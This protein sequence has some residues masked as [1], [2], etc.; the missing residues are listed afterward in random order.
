[1]R[2]LLLWCVSGLAL[3]AVGAAGAY[4]TGQ[5]QVPD[6]TVSAGT[7][8]ISAEPTSAALSVGA[9][10]PGRA[11]TRTMT[12]VN[13]GDLPVSTVVTVAKKAG[14]TAFWEAL[15]CRVT[16]AGGALYDG[17]LATMRTAPVTLAAGQRAEL[18][19]EIGLPETAGNDLAG[20]Y[21]RFTAYVD[22][23]QVR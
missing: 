4:F 2:K 10:A 17:P 22:A 12:V 9:L 8:A 15:T 13:D 23:E 11:V 3:L 21:A 1:M 16:C 19:F 6:N 5:A 7:V 14:V 18:A 20:D